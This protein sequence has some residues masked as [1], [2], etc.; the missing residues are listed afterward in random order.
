MGLVCR[1]LAGEGRGTLQ[2]YCPQFRDVDQI[3]CRSYHPH[4][5]DL[6]E[7]LCFV[8]PCNFKALAKFQAVG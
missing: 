1:L 8:N 5:Q 6:P 4:T 2:P 3:C 7:H